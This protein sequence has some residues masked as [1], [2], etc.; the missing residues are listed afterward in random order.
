M[1][2]NLTGQNISDTYQRLLQISSSGQIT[3][4][5][6]SIVIVPTASFAFTS[7]IELIK[8][9]T[10]SYAE[11]ASFANNL[12]G[13]T[14]TITELNRLDGVLSN[15]KEAYDTV[16]YNTSTGVLTFTELDNGTDTV[17]IGVGT[18]DSPSFQRLSLTLARNDSPTILLPSLDPDAVGAGGTHFKVTVDALAPGVRLG[19]TDQNILTFL[20]QEGN[21]A[22]YIDPGGAFSGNAA[23]AT[24]ATTATN[25]TSTANNSLN[26]SNYLTFVD[27]ASG[28]QGI[29][30]DTSLRY[31]YC[32]R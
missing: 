8:E 10:S 5:T 9:V 19:T 32:L 3:D 7:S 31:K 25:I 29:E 12:T 17:N 20:D 30:T 14:A 27:G 23:T 13:L 24:T 15:V 11:T 18:N 26:E 16:S 6:G 28:A 1:P 2:N 22:S 4:G 21:D